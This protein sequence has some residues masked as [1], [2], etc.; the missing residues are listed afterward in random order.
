MC[1]WQSRIGVKSQDA[2]VLPPRRRLWFTVKP[3]V[4]RAQRRGQ[5]PATKQYE[6]DVRECHHINS[7]LSDETDVS[8]KRSLLVNKKP[9]RCFQG[10]IPGYSGFLV[11][12]ATATFLRHDSADVVVP[13]LTGRELLDEF[14]IE[15]WAIDFGN[16]GHAG[17]ISPCKSVR[18]LQRARDA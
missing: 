13:Y 7:A 1:M 16:S 10:K 8:T 4:K 2:S 17:G 3:T 15:R 12:E 11:D 6:L 18:P 9:K 5:G 14:E